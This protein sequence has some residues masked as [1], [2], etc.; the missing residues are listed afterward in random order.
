MCC[1]CVLSHVQLCD[2]ARLPSPWGFPGKNTGADHHFLYQ[3]TLPIQG[4][5]PCLLCLLYC[6]QILHPLSHQGS[7]T[8]TMPSDF[9]TEIWLGIFS[10]IYTLRAY[11]IEKTKTLNSFQYCY[12]ETVVHRVRDEANCNYIGFTDF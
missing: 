4:S 3:G 10:G 11:K 2:P 7:P 6:R 5:N 12:S 1:T 8:E 9:K